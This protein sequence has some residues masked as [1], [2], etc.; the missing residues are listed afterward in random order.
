[1][2]HENPF[3]LQQFLPY[4]LNQAAE[5]TSMEFKDLYKSRHGL[6]RTEW[7]VLFHL[8][9]YGELMAKD[10]CQR[11]QL[12]KTKVSRAVTALEK[13]RLLRRKEVS[14]DRRHELLSLTSQGES[15]FRDLRDQA[16][17]FSQVLSQRI[18]KEQQE[19]LVRALLALLESSDS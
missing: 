17:H 19:A 16:E 18:G 12:H 6:L 5:A 15:V 10:I 4:L 11:G 8:G 3:P 14:T 13:R 9:C 1:M 7:R 2:N